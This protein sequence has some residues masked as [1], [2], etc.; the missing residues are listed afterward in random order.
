MSL[1]AE[2][3]NSAELGRSAAQCLCRD[4]R[5]LV[6]HHPPDLPALSV[7]GQSS[8][9]ARVERL[10]QSGAWTDAALALIDLEL[11]QCRCVGLPMTK[12]N[13]L[14]A[15]GQRELPDWL[16]QSIEALNAD[17]ALALLKRVRRG[18]SASARPEPPAFRPCGPTSTRSTSRLQRQFRPKATLPCNS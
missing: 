14:R 17:L 7:H 6:R 13:A 3:Q 2:L 15:V 1:L 5:I 12:A 16:D 8:K 18:P 9:T 11:P 10:I 4:G